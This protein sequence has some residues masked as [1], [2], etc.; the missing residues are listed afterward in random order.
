MPAVVGWQCCWRPKW[1]RWLSEAPAFA[2]GGL[3]EFVGLGVVGD[4]HFLA[5]P[6]QFALEAIGQDAESDPFSERRSD[7]EIGASRVATLAGS[8]PVAVMA[9][10]AGE[11]FRRELVISHSLHRQEPGVLT[12]GSGGDEA[13]RADKQAAVAAR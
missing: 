4:A 9:R 2:N 10:G 12:V 3:D 13:F 8:N 6:F 1:K 7:I 5:V 11:E